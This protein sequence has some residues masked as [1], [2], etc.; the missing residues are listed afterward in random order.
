MLM[1]IA[2]SRCTRISGMGASTSRSPPSV[3]STMPPVVSTPWLANF[4]SSTNK[5][6]A[7][8][9][10]TSAAKRTEQNEDHAHRAGHDRARMVE[11]HVERKESN[12][13]QQ[14][15]NVGIHEAI[16]DLLLQRHFK[17]ADG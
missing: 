12:R 13:E 15:G 14:E 6:K 11:L 4:A 5:A 3:S 16:E 17:R 8:A 2:V 7:T 1:A 9:I 10:A